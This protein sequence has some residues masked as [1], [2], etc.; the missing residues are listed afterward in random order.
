VS[1]VHVQVRVGRERYAVDVEHVG[2]VAPLGEPTPVPGS[3]SAVIGVGNVQG[4]LVP[5][6][7]LAALLEIGAD[8][9]PSR[10]VIIADGPHHAAL[11]VDDVEE[12]ARLPEATETADS[13]LLSGAVLVE[14]VLVGLID[15]PALLARAAGPMES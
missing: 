4:Q 10:M 7:R 13:P 14:G 11:A 12:V 1:T 2:G 9:S 3:P 15:I 8:P 5:V 6:L